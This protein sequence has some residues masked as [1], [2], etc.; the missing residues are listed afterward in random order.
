MIEYIEKAKLG[1]EELVKLLDKK[2]ENIEIDKKNEID[3]AV[4]E[5]N[6]KYD[7]RLDLYKSDR[8][9]YVDL[10]AIEKPDEETS[11]EECAV[12]E[13]TAEDNAE[14]VINEETGYVNEQSNF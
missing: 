13:D 4:A 8:K 10:V 6:A 14:S 12:A 5:I 9:H 3:K 1:E 7:E 2:I 11:E